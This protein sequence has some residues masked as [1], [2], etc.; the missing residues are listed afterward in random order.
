LQ[1]QEQLSAS[2]ENIRLAEHLLSVSQHQLDAGLAS[3]VD[4]ARS[5]TQLAQQ[6]ARQEQLRLNV[7]KAH[8][9]L[10]RIIKIPLSQSIE[11][12]DDLTDDE[13]IGMNVEEAI[14]QAQQNRIE[15]RL[16]HAE[17]DYSVA[18]LKAA[19]RERFPKIE[20]G[21]DFGLTGVTPTEDAQRAAQA[22]VRVTMPIWEGGRIAGAIKEQTGLNEEENI[23]L[24]DLNLRVEED[25]R[26]ALETLMSNYIQVQATQKVADLAQQELT[27]AQDRFTSGVGN[28]TDVIN[29]ETILSNAHD[30]Y[31]Q[32]LAQYNQA[33]LNYFAALGD[34]MQF[35]LPMNEKEGKN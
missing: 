33:Q 2:A 5:R 6:E 30:F 3:V 10:K 28:N 29:A 21:G 13:R 25:V 14:A 16:A 11:L 26:L 19:K 4:V 20:M 9:T 15:L 32:T 27:L 8:M 1:Y 22:S 12:T 31:V 24:N 7:I 35:N 17:L 18:E 23:K 34:P